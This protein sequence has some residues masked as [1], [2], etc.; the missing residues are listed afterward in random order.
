MRPALS[1]LLLFYL[2]SGAAAAVNLCTMRPAYAAPPR[3]SNHAALPQLWADTAAW[4]ASPMT[5]AKFVV[6]AALAAFALYL[7][8]KFFVIARR[9]RAKTKP[10]VRKESSASSIQ[11]EAKSFFLRVQE[12]WDRRDLDALAAVAT[13]GMLTEIRAQAEESPEPSFTDILW[14]KADLVSQAEKEGSQQAV[15]YFT[16]LL[17]EDVQQGDAVEVREIWRLTRPLSCDSWLLDSI[18]HVKG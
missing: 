3:Q 2:T 6:A 4:L 7:G 18:D 12:A 15:I 8:L 13:P 5:P 14:V 9:I 10:V 16:L 1:S 11:D 17:R